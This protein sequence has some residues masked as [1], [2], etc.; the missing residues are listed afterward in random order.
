MHTNDK[1][2]TLNLTLMGQPI[3]R[4]GLTK[5]E[6]SFKFLGLWIEQDLSWKDHCNKI[7]AKIWKLTYTINKLKKMVH[8][9]HLAFIYRGLI[10]P[11]IEYGLAIWGHNRT[12]AMNLAHKKI[13]RIINTKLKHTH[14]EPLLKNMNCLQLE[15]LYN[16]KVLD[17]LHKIRTK[18]AP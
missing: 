5:P 17:Q 9:K 2:A 4:V 13:I 8:T 11:V 18:R 16:Q 6:T 10:K 7:R 15:D 12:K 14:V 3:K 1:A